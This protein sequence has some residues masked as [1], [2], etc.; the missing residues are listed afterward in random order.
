MV[1]GLGDS[2]E[3]GGELTRRRLLAATGGLGSVVLAGCLGGDSSGATPTDEGGAGAAAGSDGSGMGDDDQSSGSMDS[4]DGTADAE[5][6]GDSDDSMDGDSDDSMDGDSDDSMD[7]GETEATADLPSWYDHELTDVTTGETFTVADLDG[8]VVIQSFAVWCPKCQSQ[9]ENL[10]AF[11]ERTDDVT[12]VSLNTDPNEDA[13]KVRSHAENNG[14][15]W[16]FA[17]SPADLT[18]TLVEEFGAVVT[19]APSTPV[20]VACPDG[21]A[22]LI[23][24]RSVKS[25]ET[26]A[27]HADQC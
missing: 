13:G 20:I 15:D 1:D 3:S 11:R 9:S 17:V 24:Q 10:S 7:G 6:D 27:E 8:P 2:G 18:Q 21:S 23:D 25:A 16:R 5:M 14:F 22:S 12:V 19:N 4:P 26:V